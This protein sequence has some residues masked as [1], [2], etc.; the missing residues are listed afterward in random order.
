MSDLDDAAADAA[1]DA[2]TPVV[3]A[4]PVWSSS[5]LPPVAHRRERLVGPDVTRALALVGVV[6]MNYHGYLNGIDAA[7]GSDA[8]LPQRWFDPWTGVLST[9]FAA[10]FVL[11]AGVGVTLLTQR[12]RAGGD[13]AAIRDDRW[14]LVRRGVLLYA[15]GFVLDWIW[16]GTILFFYGAFFM[17]AALLFTL[18]TRW[19]VAVG[20]AAAIAAAL[21][22]W[23][24]VVHDRDGD[25]LSWLTSPDT[26]SSRS[27]RGLVLDTFVNGTHPLLPWLAFLCAG[28]VL[29]RSLGRVRLGLVAAAGA[30]VTA[31]TYLVNHL[32]TNGHADDVVRVAIWST[33][34]FDRGLLYTLGTLGS[35]LAAFCLVSLAAERWR[36]TV[37]VRVL[38]SA[39]EMTLSIY[40]AHVFVF[41]G[42]VDRAEMV[43]GTGLDTALVFSLTFW[44]FAL[45]IAAW[46]RRFVGLGP[47]ERIYRRFGG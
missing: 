7:A 5:T 14:R 41:R 3:T 12:S 36:S 34:P 19:L 46:W 37:L 30:S 38:R 32:L 25:P 10:T 15:V 43:G 8:T 23:Q 47:L 4:G 31:L 24:V 29:G 21:I 27:P 39:G 2:A 44:V 33:R 11:V 28:M 6:I 17:A 45:A 42:L 35:S 9:R 13:R 16:P 20:A 1:A 40:V 18:R 22:Q 26:L